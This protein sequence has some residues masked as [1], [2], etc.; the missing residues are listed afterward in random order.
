MMMMMPRSSTRKLMEIM[1]L[2]NKNQEVT[3][4]L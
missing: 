3:N 4:G 2:E 1:I